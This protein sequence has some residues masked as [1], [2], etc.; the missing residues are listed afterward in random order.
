MSID[1][2]YVKLITT[3]FTYT[4]TTEKYSKVNSGTCASK[5]L[6]VISSKN[7][8]EKTARYLVLSVTSA[9][10]ATES[11]TPTGCVFDGFA[12]VFNADDNDVA[13]GTKIGG[14]AIDCICRA[15]KFRL[16][17]HRNIPNFQFTRWSFC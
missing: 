10:Q 15:G 12:L 6:R 17:P 3:I 5:S 8:C 2:R 14:L 16:F 4:D 13:C 9:V 11:D 1:A 7:E